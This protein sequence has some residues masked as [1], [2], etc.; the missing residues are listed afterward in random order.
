MG[1]FGFTLRRGLAIGLVVAAGWLL[2]NPRGAKADIT[3]T[4]SIPGLSL[5]ITF[6][7]PFSQAGSTGTNITINTQTLNSILAANGSGYSFSG[8]SA[9]SN[10]PGG[11]T[12]F[13][14]IT[15]EA[16]FSGPGSNTLTI[17]AT[18]L[19]FQSPSGT[20]GLIGTATGIFTNTQAGDTQS[21]ITSP[22]PPFITFTSTGPT[23]NSYSGSTPAVPFSAL[24]PYSLTESVA[25]T[26]SS[27]KDQFGAT[28]EVGPNVPEPTGAG[29]LLIGAGVLIRRRRT[30]R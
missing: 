18:D 20:N 22:A 2:S 9:T 5:P 4:V 23:P 26:L 7:G 19:S 6:N 24:A 15:G 13:L 14:S 1:I 29:L 21:V 10:S 25:L 3:L 12:A 28:V 16:L 17:N 11:S 30:A 27:G 8:L